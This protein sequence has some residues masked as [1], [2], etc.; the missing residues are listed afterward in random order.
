M[1]VPTPLDGLAGVVRPV[2]GFFFF[3]AMLEVGRGRAGFDGFA[4]LGL[5]GL[6]AGPFAGC[7]RAEEIVVGFFVGFLLL[8]F[9]VELVAGFFIGFLLILLILFLLS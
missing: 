7:L 1:A 6:L 2:V 4:G 8:T 3:L 5:I 9:F